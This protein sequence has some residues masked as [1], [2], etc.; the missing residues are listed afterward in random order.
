MTN[1]QRIYK[2]YRIHVRLCP[3]DED[4]RHHDKQLL[5][6][7]VGLVQPAH[8]EENTYERTGHKEWL[9]WS[10]LLRREHGEIQRAVREA[11]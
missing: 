9:Q 5:S 11:S 3:E 8:S 4:L 6:I 1:I 7:W 10:E 2:Y